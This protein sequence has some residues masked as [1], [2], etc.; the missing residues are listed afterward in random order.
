MISYGAHTRFARAYVEEAV[1]HTLAAERA[2]E[3]L[4]DRVPLTVIANRE[5][6]PEEDRNQHTL[7]VA[8]SPSGMFKRCPGSRGHL[9]CNYLTIDLY[10]GCTL[11]CSYC[12]M[13]SYLSF[14]PITVYADLSP[15]IAGLREVARRNPDKEIRVGTGEVGDSLLYDP[16]FRLSE[17]LIRGVADLPNVR[18]ELKTKSDF[19]DHLL[20]LEP[21]GRSVIG[22]SLNPQEIIDREEGWAASLTARLDAARRVAEAGY[23]VAFHFDPIIRLSNWRE[24]YEQVVR[25]LEPFRSREVAWVSLGTVRFTRALR[26]KIEER[27]YLYDEFFPSRDGKLRYLQKERVEVYRAMS[28]WLEESVGA[29]VYLCMESAAVWRRAFGGEPSTLSRGVAELFRW[30]LGMPEEEKKE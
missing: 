27:P 5:E 6:I 24:L 9:C 12:I 4:G 20:D 21:K 15:A 8:R 19:V 18:L 7:F 29:R 28:R 11:G 16:I 14:S 25:E 3:F 30:P 1:V 10:A 2:R 13:K 17:E 22:F 26:E 23:A